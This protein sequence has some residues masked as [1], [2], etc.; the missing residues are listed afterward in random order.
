MVQAEKI[1]IPM[2]DVS[3]SGLRSDLAVYDDLRLDFMWKPLKLNNGVVGHFLDW[4]I[5]CLLQ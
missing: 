3:A 5:F 1:A 4:N 2:Y